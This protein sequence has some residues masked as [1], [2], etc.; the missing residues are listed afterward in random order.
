MIFNCHGDTH[1]GLVKTRN[2]DRYL[3]KEINGGLLLV[4]ADGL[5][6]NPS[7]DVAAQLVVDSLESFQ[8][9]FEGSLE[10]Q[11]TA[12]VCRA[13][14]LVLQ[15]GND[16]SAL[17]GMGSTVTVA[18]VMNDQVCW[19]HVGDSRLYH[20][21]EGELEQLTIDQN[22]GQELYER[23]EI[24]ADELAGHKMRNFLSQCIGEDEIEPVSGHLHLS[25]GDQLL[26]S[27]DGLHDLV[28][29]IEIKGILSLKNSVQERVA[30]LIIV[31]L[32]A[33]GNDNITVVLDEA[34][35]SG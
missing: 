4:V 2:E 34:G 8:P 21:R 17:Q 28:Q 7:G 26:L 18:L 30:R 29:D 13:N 14:E 22:L 35:C 27:T 19:A 9:H 31:G 24:S 10:L 3:I 25:P 32:E 11:L 20:F 16:N 1:I 6:G 33:G 5:G 12:A 15:V 23:G